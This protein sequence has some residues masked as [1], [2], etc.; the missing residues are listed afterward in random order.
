ME[1]GTGERARRDP[2]LEAPARHVAPG[3]WRRAVIGFLA[4]LLAGVLLA[5]VM[6]RDDG[7]RRRD[8]RLGEGDAR[9]GAGPVRP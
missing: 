8:L 4:G 3:G 9:S 6:P 7:P 5:L 2:P 1:H